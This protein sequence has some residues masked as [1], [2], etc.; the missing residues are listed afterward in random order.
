MS[1]QPVL[2]LQKRTGTG[3]NAVRKYRRQGLAPGILYGHG[4]EPLPVVI[5]AHA[6]R[7]TVPV[8]QYGSQVVRVS[9]D[10]SEAGMALVKAVQINTVSRQILNV[11]FLSVS[12]EDHVNVSVSVVVEGESPD[13]RMGAVLEQIHHSVNLRCSAFEV[14]SQIIV[15]ISELHIGDA[16]HAGQ[17]PLPVGS[18]LHQS[19]EDVILLIVSP[20]KAL[21]EEAVEV[22]TTPTDASGVGSALT[23]EKQKE[24]SPS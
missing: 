22:E 6:F 7:M 21:T 3:S 9:M 19:A 13:F 23:G 17:L 8:D 2:E 12:S 5:D 11:D 14:P 10:G 16:I 4:A 1:E 15:D 20:T 18:E 24:S